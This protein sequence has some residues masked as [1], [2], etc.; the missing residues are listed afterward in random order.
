MNS[1]VDM[2]DNRI[3]ELENRSIEFIQWEQKKTKQTNKKIK[4]KKDEQDPVGQ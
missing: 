2:T 3:G 4:I 1:M